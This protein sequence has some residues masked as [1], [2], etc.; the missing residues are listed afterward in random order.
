VTSSLIINETTATIASHATRA[1]AADRPSHGSDR[2]R[3]DSDLAIA[4]LAVVPVICAGVSLVAGA[5][6]GLYWLVPA[7]IFVFISAAVKAW[8]LL[9]EVMR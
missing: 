9:V 4:Q 5:G 1:T 8:V 6:G 7:L 2:L 3:Q